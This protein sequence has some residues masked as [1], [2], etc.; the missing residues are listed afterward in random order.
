MATSDPIAALRAKTATTAAPNLSSLQQPGA[1][2]SPAAAP[3]APQGDQDADQGDSA[4]SDEETAGTTVNLKRA[5]SRLQ[6]AL[7]KLADE[8]GIKRSATI[9][10]V[11]G[12]MGAEHI[13]AVGQAV[14][15]V[16]GLTSN[17]LLSAHHSHGKGF[18][19]GDGHTVSFPAEK[20]RQTIV[21]KDN[22]NAKAAVDA[23]R[24]YVNKIHFLIGDDPTVKAAQA[25]LKIIG[26]NNMA[27][28][29]LSD[30]V[31]ALVGIV[32]R[33]TQKVAQAHNLYKHGTHVAHLTAPK[34]E[35]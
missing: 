4:Q 2:A 21:T 25:Q 27:G 33:P 23:A 16:G 26:S 14:S 17:L 5:Y 1:Q 10:Y 34:I 19:S 18:G 29:S 13:N 22:E 12:Q 35:G 15:Q 32:H 8:S 6:E 30:C 9:P 20:L 31:I 28:M 11:E 24:N 3:A 7:I